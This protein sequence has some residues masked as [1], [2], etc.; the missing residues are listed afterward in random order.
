MKSTAYRPAL[1]GS[2]RGARG[3][4]LIEL[5]VSLAVIGLLLALLVPAVQSV[6]E[7]GRGTQCRSNL[8]QV[9]TAFNNYEQ[10]YRAFP[11][12]AFGP[13][14][15]A[16][17]PFI[18]ILPGQ[19]EVAV[20]ACPSETWADGSIR[21]GRVSY[22][23]NNGVYQ[24]RPGGDGI[25]GSYKN[26]TSAQD[27]TDGLSNTAALS[28]RPVI[29]GTEVALAADPKN[30]SPQEQR[31]F[32]TVLPN[33]HDTIPAFADECEK[34]PRGKGFE[35]MQDLVYHHVVPPNRLNCY[36]G[37]PDNEAVIPYALTAA[38]DH[39]QGVNLTLADGSIRFVSDAIAREVWWAIGTRSGGESA[40]LSAL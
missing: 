2:R 16:I 9:I 38:S 10:T 5:L 14:Y 32:V 29:P 23:P 24:R 28:E 31:W 19:E 3:F 11:S 4:T 27:I 20:Y 1:G 22:L 18:E 7:S 34:S 36:N 8:H 25:L 21:F 6:R 40:G 15:Q 12:N 35:L 30:L 17:G 26:P 39:P 13:Y 33:E 37:W